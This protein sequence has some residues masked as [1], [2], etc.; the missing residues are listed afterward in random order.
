MEKEELTQRLIEKFGESELIDSII[1][2]NL[3]L[4]FS[5]MLHKKAN[6]DEDYVG[7][8]ESYNKMCEEIANARIDM[9]HLSYI[10][11]MYEI[12]NHYD[13]MTQDLVKSLED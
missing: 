13:N 11:N 3:K 1:E 8:V 12:N 2:K 9:D 5:L 6:K 10:F 7:Y 4:S